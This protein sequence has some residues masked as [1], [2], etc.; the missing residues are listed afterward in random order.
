MKAAR[1]APA[2]AL[3]ASVRPMSSLQ[4]I[5]NNRNAPTAS[6]TSSATCKI[7]S[8]EPKCMGPLRLQP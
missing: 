7:H 4:L 1:T 3:L 5:A 8:I 6:S 2:A